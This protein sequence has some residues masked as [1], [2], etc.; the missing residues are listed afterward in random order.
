[1]SLVATQS[2]RPQAEPLI[3]FERSDKPQFTYVD[4]IMSY[5]FVV[6]KTHWAHDVVAT[7]DQR[8]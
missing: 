6:V 4:L 7:L 3:W 1:M 8:Q 5:K 2:T